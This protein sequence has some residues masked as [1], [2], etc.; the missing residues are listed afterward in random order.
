[1][2]AQCAAPEWQRDPTRVTFAPAGEEK[3][4]FQVRGHTADPTPETEDDPKAEE[5]P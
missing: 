5:Q 3:R 1:V 2:G 4:T